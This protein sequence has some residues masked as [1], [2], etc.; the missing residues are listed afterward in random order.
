MTT[1]ERD[2]HPI[3]EMLKR[4]SQFKITDFNL[5]KKLGKGR[6]GS[7]RL[8]QDKLTK[9]ILAIKTINIAQLK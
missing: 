1:R 3:K 8:A 6:F 2:I 7:V 4:S 5:G 9:F